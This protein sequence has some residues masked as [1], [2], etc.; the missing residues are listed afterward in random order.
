MEWNHNLTMVKLDQSYGQCQ[1][2]ED[3]QANNGK[4]VVTKLM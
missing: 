3:M 1:V 4:T 2:A